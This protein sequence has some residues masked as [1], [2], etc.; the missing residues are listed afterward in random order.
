[1]GRTCLTDQFSVLVPPIVISHNDEEKQKYN[2]FKNLGVDV[3]KLLNNDVDE[4]R[5]LINIQDVFI[6]Q[7][8]KRFDLTEKEK[9][10]L[11]E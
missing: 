6:D 3:E 11:N 7:Y 8:A 4:Y 5:K 1:M 10:E 2:L 9:L